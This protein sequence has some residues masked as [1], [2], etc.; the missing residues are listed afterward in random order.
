[1]VVKPTR[2]LGQEKFVTVFTFHTVHHVDK[3]DRDV[4]AP[5][6]F[7]PMLTIA[8]TV[9]TKDQILIPESLLKKRKTEEKTQAERDQA[10]AEKKK[11]ILPSKRP[12]AMMIPTLS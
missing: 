5:K 8:R 2:F 1:L 7:N 6:P 3:S 11:V 4:L 9:P 10:L 12:T